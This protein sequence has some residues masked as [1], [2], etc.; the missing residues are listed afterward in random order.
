MSLGFSLIT[1]KVFIPFQ[2]NLYS[3]S[4]IGNPN[5]LNRIRNWIFRLSRISYILYESILQ[6]RSCTENAKPHQILSFLGAWAIFKRFVCTTLLVTNTCFSYYR[7]TRLFISLK[8]VHIPFQ[9]Y[10]SLGFSQ[11]RIETNLI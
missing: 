4:T 9:I 6:S 7:R 3:I 10:I 11:N 1:F 2:S 8:P 5:I